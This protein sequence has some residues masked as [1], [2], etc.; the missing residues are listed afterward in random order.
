MKITEAPSRLAGALMLG[1]GLGHVRFESPAQTRVAG[2]TQQIVDVM[3]LAPSHDVLPTETGIAADNDACL[4]PVLAN[5]ADDAFEFVHTA[6][7]AIGVRRPQPRA[8]QVFA[9]E[10]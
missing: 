8:Q 4:G 2:Q 5:L 3:S 10:D 1:P 9:T 7:S 6:G